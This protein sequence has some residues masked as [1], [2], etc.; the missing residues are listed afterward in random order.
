MSLVQTYTS[1]SHSTSRSS[2]AET[3][4]SIINAPLTV[5][6]S[7][8]PELVQTILDDLKAALI[9]NKDGRLLSE[10][11]P[12]ALAT[13]K[14]LGRM[15]TE[16]AVLAKS[17]NLALLL[18][19]YN[20]LDNKQ[21]GGNEAL[22]CV[23]NTLLLVEAARMTWISEDVEGGETCVE[24]LQTK[25]SPEAIFLISRILFLC[26]ASSH[27][28][29]VFITKLV[30]NKRSTPHG[31][32]TIVDIIEV[33]LDDLLNDILAGTP[34]AR[35]AMMDLLKFIFNL[36]LHYPKIVDCEI[37]TLGA[38]ASTSSAT[39][40]SKVM[41]DFWSSRLDGILAP[42]LRVFNYLPLATS[43]PLAPPL[44]H[45]LHSLIVI[46]V[47]SSLRVTWF[48]KRSSTSSTSRQSPKPVSSSA[49]SAS[50]QSLANGDDSTKDSPVS[51]SPTITSS[52]TSGREHRVRPAL[53][54]AL[55]AMVS[56]SR[57]SFSS[58]PSSVRSTSRAADTVQRATDL[59]DVSLAHFISGSTD[60]DD[61]SVREL[62][63]R[64]GETNLDAI[65]CPLVV[66]LTRFCHSDDP[67][68]LRLRNWLVPDNLDRSTPLQHRADTLG[69]CLRLLASMYHSRLCDAMGGFLFA[70]CDS[71][72][73]TLSA[74]FGYGN[75]AG[76]L[77]KK[78]IVA[79]PPQSSLTVTGPDA[80][81]A[82]NP[83][84]GT[85]QEEQPE[86]DMT[87]E[88]KEQEA[89]KLFSLFERLE[90]TGAIQPSQN[91]VRTAIQRSMGGNP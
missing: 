78:N 10:D 43:N 33:K 11:A 2:V 34:M 50:E 72:A 60:P 87:E 38:R 35:E 61:P 3:L 56:A 80:G 26:T 8:R 65:L 71:D 23:A 74:Y 69:R 14:A 51:G 47:S 15:P 83:I 17:S 31:T 7:A 53:D 62:C 68:K 22:R 28:S 41:G 13:L 82:I 4:Q 67:V 39:D 66:L 24:L 90:R 40:A 77:F 75:V 36:L 1:F 63:K 59:L 91:P 32:G 52:P 19:F 88:E 81:R 58:R 25:T 6:P 29:G 18:K 16:A 76:F 20:K 48:G 73:A 86:L 49:S 12:L 70:M 5:D 30:E 46:P 27:S 42:L 64:E 44:T 89:E 55:S 37:Q 54:K 57:R 79:P 45:V 84:T 9:D 21:E 85:Y